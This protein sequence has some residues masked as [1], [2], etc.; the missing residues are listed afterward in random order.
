M[1]VALSSSSAEEEGEPSLTIGALSN[2]A[3]ECYQSDDIV[4]AC[5]YLDDIKD[6]LVIIALL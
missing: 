1:Q 4:Q 2:R 5:L 6:K 3:N